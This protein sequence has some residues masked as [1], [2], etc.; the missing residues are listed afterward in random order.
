MNIYVHTVNN[1]IAFQ[2]HELWYAK[3]LYRFK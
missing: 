2:R 3:M 1:I